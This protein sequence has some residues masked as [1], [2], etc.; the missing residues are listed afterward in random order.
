MYFD[1]TDEK[2]IAGNLDNDYHCYCPLEGNN[3]ELF[4]NALKINTSL[5]K[6]YFSNFNN[7]KLDPEIFRKILIVLRNKNLRELS[8]HNVLCSDGVNMLADFLSC[9]PNLVKLS[10]SEYGNADDNTK[11]M[12]DSLCCKLLYCKHGKTNDNIKTIMNSL[13]HNTNLIKFSIWQPNIT[14]DDV[15]SATLMLKHNTTLKCLSFD[16]IFGDTQMKLFADMLYDNTSLESVKLPGNRIKD[17]SILVN[18][19]KHNTSLKNLD[20][21]RNNIG[22]AG[23]L[24]LA[25]LLLI[26]PRLE[27]LN[28][29]DCGI[30]IGGVIE[31]CKQSSLRTLDCT[32]NDYTQKELYG[33]TD[34]LLNNTTLHTLKISNLVSSGINKIVKSLDNNYALTN[35][36]IFKKCKRGTKLCSSKSLNAYL[37]RNINLQVE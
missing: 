18:S 22:I 33:L 5:Q 35:V 19:L 23:A 17:I 16:T 13:H 10:Y 27:K 20:L 25:D 36:Q 30:C 11:T 34:V 14:C 32:N 21:R 26:N 37:K 12:M 15:A 4:I 3:A 7:S 29:S 2:L 1:E 31:L 8:F 6:I 9:N 24:M 28:V